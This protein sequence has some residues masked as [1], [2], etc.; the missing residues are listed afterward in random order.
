MAENSRSSAFSLNRL[1]IPIAAAALTGLLVL[2]SSFLLWYHVGGGAW[3]SEVGIIEVRLGAPDTLILSVASCHGGPSASVK[4][5]TA[6]VVQIEVVAFSTPMHSR[7]DCLDDVKAHLREPLRDRSIVDKHTGNIFSGNLQPYAS[8]KP[9][10]NWRLVEVPGL[11]NQPGFSIR[12]PF[13]WELLQTHSEGSY[14]GEV[15]GDDGIQLRFD[16]GKT[17]WSL[18]PADVSA[19]DYFVT[20]EDIGGLEAKLVIAMDAAQKYTGVYFP[21]LGGHELSF[22]GE[23]LSPNQMGP[24]IAVFRSIR[25]LE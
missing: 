24:T 13:G 14:T 18:D 7:R 4:E 22:V 8:G 19:H 12:L 21:D 9:Q 5:E 16:Y 23:D 6:A 15:I 11:P 20:Y 2:I 17:A 10:P 3:R 1:F 25:L